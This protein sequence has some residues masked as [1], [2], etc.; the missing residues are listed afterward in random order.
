[1]ERG[2]D[3]YLWSLSLLAKHVH[4]CVQFAHHA[5]HVINVIA[6]SCDGNDYFWG[7]TGATD[8]EKWDRTVASDKNVAYVG[9]WDTF[10]RLSCRDDDG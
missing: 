7:A 3:L 10:P 9:A 4:N 1:M 2:N 8:K 5:Y 6:A